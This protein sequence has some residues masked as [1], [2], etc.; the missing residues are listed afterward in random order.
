[1][2]I[3]ERAFEK[4]H[5]PCGWSLKQIFCLISD[6]LAE[7]WTIYNTTAFLMAV[8]DCANS[9]FWLESCYYWIFIIDIQILIVYRLRNLGLYCDIIRNYL[10]NGFKKGNYTSEFRLAV[11]IES[12]KRFTKSGDN[13][14]ENMSCQDIKEDWIWQ[15]FRSKISVNHCF[16]VK[17]N[18]SIWNIYT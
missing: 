9:D 10:L 14:S 18:Y 2:H 3:P 15:V 11:G 4:T 13:P 8:H 12:R 16:T 6:K 17:W 7:D 1:M 5:V